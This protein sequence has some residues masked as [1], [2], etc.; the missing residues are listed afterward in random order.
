MARGQTIVETSQLDTTA[1][2]IEGLADT[3]NKN[4]MALF[5]AVQEMQAAWAGKDNTA[6]TTQIEGFRDDFQRMEQLMREY[7]SFLKK[8]AAAYR[9]TQAD[10]EA[11]A[12]T[13]SQGS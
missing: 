13:L 2:N 5:T 6:Y 7:A 1:A 10:I 9:Q 11:K 8:S 12:R 3:Y 4:Y